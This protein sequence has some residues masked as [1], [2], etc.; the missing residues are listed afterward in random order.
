MSPTNGST[1]GALLPEEAVVDASV[2]IKLFVKEE[3]SEVAHALFDQSTGNPAAQL[4]VPD[5]FYIECMNILWK[6]V[7]RF[8]YPAEQAHQDAADLKVL[9]LRRTPTSDLAGEALDLGLTY[10]IT[11]Y[12]AAYV[13]LAR[14]QELPLITADERL[15]R[16]E[17][18]PEIRVRWL[19]DLKR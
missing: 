5:L 18:G 1:G 3:L 10:G 12:D 2:G 13:A 9:L 4:H 14:L 11:A 19:G 17:F 8:S 7:R 16:T 6:Y 15:A